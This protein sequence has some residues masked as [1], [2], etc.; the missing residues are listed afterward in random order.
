MQKVA[1]DAGLGVILARLPFARM[2]IENH[3]RIMLP[4]APTGNANWGTCSIAS[5]LDALSFVAI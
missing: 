2:A 4:Y 5:A 1:V 3:D